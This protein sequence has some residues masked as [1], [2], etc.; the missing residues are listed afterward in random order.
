[1]K[2][3]SSQPEIGSDPRLESISCQAVNAGSGDDFFQELNQIIV[4][5]FKSDMGQNTHPCTML[6]MPNVTD[7]IDFTPQTFLSQ[8]AAPTLEDALFATFENPSDR[9][10]TP[11]K[12]YHVP[13]MIDDPFHFDWPYW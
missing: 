9:T 1:M 5:N 6:S 2:P 10:D 4:P 7:T 11:N 13:T 12:H 8:I 3:R